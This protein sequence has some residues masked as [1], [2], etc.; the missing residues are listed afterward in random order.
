MKKSKVII[1]IVLAV[2][3]V[4]ICVSAPTFSWFTRPQS[5][6]QGDKILLNTKNSYTAYNG[7]SVKFSTTESATGY[8]DT[9]TITPSSY[10]GDSNHKI[11]IYNRRYFCTTITNDSNTDQNVSLYASRLSMPI[12]NN[13][14]LALGVNGPTRSYRNYTELTKQPYKT[15]DNYDMRIYFQ[16]NNVDGWTGKNIYVSY[17]TPYHEQDYDG[18]KM[19]C[20]SSDGGSTFYADIPYNCWGVYFSAEGWETANHNTN[21]WS[22]DWTMRSVTINDLST[23]GQ[24]QT[25]SKIF[26]LK[27]ND[28]KDEN[29]NRTMDCYSATGASVLKYCNSVQVKNGETFNTAAS[30]VFRAQSGSISYSS[31][32]TSVFTVDGSGVITGG[33]AGTATLTTKVRSGTGWNDEYWVFTNVTVTSERNYDFY[34]VPIVKNIKIPGS[35]ENDANIVK[36][37]WYV[38]NNST[39]TPLEY[40]I[41]DIY[42]GL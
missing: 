36:V 27:G 7:K 19:T 15:T 10:S 30:D 21:P 8:E 41:D 28:Y 13:G 29:N 39:T 40:Y 32:D 34:D 25:Q 42:L 35:K 16:H 18:K 31:S 37:Y 11:P 4:V 3:L 2:A 26:K 23:W 14:T 5:H 12:A 9:Y 22:Q 20:I 24:S 1:A 17:H 33:G 38:I 6:D